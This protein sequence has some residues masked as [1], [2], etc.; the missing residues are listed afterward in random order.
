MSYTSPVPVDHPRVMAWLYFWMIML[1]WLLAS[2]HIASFDAGLGFL[3][4]AVNMV[5]GLIARPK[6]IEMRERIDQ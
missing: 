1:M 3:I 2:V 5:I 6:V 4:G